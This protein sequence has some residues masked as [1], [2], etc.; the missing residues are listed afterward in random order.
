MHSHRT[1]QHL[2]H[3]TEM[4]IPKEHPQLM[5]I[6]IFFPFQQGSL[7]PR[8]PQET[9][10]VSNNLLIGCWPF[11]FDVYCLTLALFLLQSSFGLSLWACWTCGLQLQWS[12]TN[13]TLWNRIKTH[14]YCYTLP[15]M[16]CTVRGFKNGYSH[17]IGFGSDAICIQSF[18]YWCVTECDFW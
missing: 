11:G 1:S 7:L 16:L 17:S 10:K 3:Y 12:I 9:H 2:M 18:L 4:L 13:L 14:Q 5:L 8:W 6:Y 15:V